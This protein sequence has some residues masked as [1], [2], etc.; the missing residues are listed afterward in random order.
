MGVSA[1]NNSQRGPLGHPDP[2]TTFGQGGQHET[3]NVRHPFHRRSAG[4]HAEAA[5]EDGGSGRRV[6]NPRPASQA[7]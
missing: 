4:G 3:E 2:D 5:Q 7:L 1:G 6:L